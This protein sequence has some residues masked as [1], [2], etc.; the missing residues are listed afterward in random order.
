[1]N[2]RKIEHLLPMAHKVH[3]KFLASALE[4]KFDQVTIGLLDHTTDGVVNR[5][6]SKYGFV[7]K[8][9]IPTQTNATQYLN[10]KVNTSFVTGKL[11]TQSVTKMEE[12]FKVKK[13]K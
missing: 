9:S 11:S 5:G 3:S 10:E 6:G 12:L 2:W 4:S 1:M 7:E 8:E 13:I